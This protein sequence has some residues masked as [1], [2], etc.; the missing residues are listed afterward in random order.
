MVNWVTRRDMT[1]A[2][3]GGAGLFALAIMAV[4]AI[5]A[6]AWWW[7]SGR[8]LRGEPSMPQVVRVVWRGG[9]FA[10]VFGLAYVDGWVGAWAAAGVFVL[11]G[12]G[13]WL[14]ATTDE[15]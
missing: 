1:D 4:F 9:L 6:G 5:F 3:K 7:V 2:A 12:L 15:A 14:M 8:P 10:A 11:A 13:W